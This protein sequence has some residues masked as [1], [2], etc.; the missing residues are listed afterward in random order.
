MFK[1]CAPHIT[2]IY[3]IWGMME[4]GKWLGDFR[5]PNT[6]CIFIGCEPTNLDDIQT[7]KKIL[8]TLVTCISI[9]KESGKYCECKYLLC[10]VQQ[11]LSPAQSSPVPPPAGWP[12]VAGRKAHRGDKMN[13]GGEAGSPREELGRPGRRQP[14]SWDPTGR[15]LP[16]KFCSLESLLVLF[17]LT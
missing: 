16:T 12:L 14:R 4:D 5:L 7:K 2:Q 6:I 15:D 3:T 10:G 11:H 9:S 8:I 17:D 1:L 13:R